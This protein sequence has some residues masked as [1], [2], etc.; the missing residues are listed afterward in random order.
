MYKGTCD[1]G[2]K[3]PFS[4]RNVIFQMGVNLLITSYERKVCWSSHAV[5]IY[6]NGPSEPEQNL[7][8]LASSVQQH[9]SE[10]TDWNSS[11]D[12]LM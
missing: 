6:V 4:M 5:W 11:R 3:N 2:G 8:G 7:L 1:L 12:G 9:F 10:T